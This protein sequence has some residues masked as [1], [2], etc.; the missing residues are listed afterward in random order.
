MA[1][2]PGTPEAPRTVGRKPLS[3]LLDELTGAAQGWLSTC[4]TALAEPPGALDGLLAPDGDVAAALEN[5]ERSSWHPEWS[6][7]RAS[8]EAVLAVARAAAAE[9]GDGS[10]AADL[11]QQAARHWRTS[12]L[13]LPEA[14]DAEA[15][16]GADPADDFAGLM[17]RALRGTLGR[18]ASVSVPVLLDRGRQGGG[19]MADLTVT[20][21]RDGPAGLFPD[22]ERMAFG[23]GDPAFA[24]ALEAGWG[25]APLSL[26]RRCVLWSV[27]ELDG[28]PC[29]RLR[30]GSLGAPLG[31]ALDGLHRRL[32]PVHRSFTM[33]EVLRPRRA[34]TGRLGRD[35]ELLEVG[36][37]DAKLGAAAS[38]GYQVVAP[39]ANRSDEV[40]HK[41]AAVGVELRYA[42]H[43]PE[44][45]RLVR[46]LGRG[47][48]GLL[49]LV[50]LL[51]VLA[52]LVGVQQYRAHEQEQAARQAERESLSRALA[53]LS[54]RTGGEDPLM[55]DL[56]AAAAHDLASTPEA[57]RSVYEALH[58]PARDKLPGAGSWARFT[59]DSERIMT[60]G[61]VEG[62]GLLRE[63]SLTRREPTGPSVRPSRDAFPATGLR[64]HA[65]SPD[66]KLWAVAD[67]R[68][69][70]QLWSVPGGKRVTAPIQ[71]HRSAVGTAVFSP[72][73]GTLATVTNPDGGPSAGRNADA[74]TIRL[75]DTETGALR[76]AIVTDHTGFIHALAFSPDGRLLASGGRADGDGPT[77]RLWDAAN[78][79]RTGK[80]PGEVAEGVSAL[81]FAPDGVT[82]AAGSDDGSVRQW[83][84]VTGRR[85]GQAIVA[86]SERVR[87]LRYT[88]DG[89]V[90]V[91]ASDDT[92]VRLWEARSG[93]SIGEPFAGHTDGIRSLS[94]APDENRLVS[95]DR[96]GTV[97]VWDVNW[98]RYY[99]RP[100][101]E[102]SL[103]RSVAA[104]SPDGDRVA[105]ASW[106]GV[107]LV[108]STDGSGRGWVLGAGAGRVTG[109]AYAPDGLTLATSGAD[110]TVR[111][112]ETA[113]GKTR[114]TLTGHRGAVNALA[115]S[116]DGKT[117][118]SA[119]A[120]GTVRLWETASG[121][122]LRTLTGH[123]GAVNALTYS[124][125]GKTLATS[126]ADGTVRLWETATGKTRHTL[127]G[128]RGA[129]NALAHS[130]DG[131]T[132]AS[133]G[134][135]G[136]VRLWETASG[137]YLRTLTGHV[138][139]V[140]T[141]GFGTDDVLTGGG[142]NGV[143]QW[144]AGSGRV[145]HVFDGVGGVTGLAMAPDGSSF[146]TAGSDRAITRWTTGAPE[147]EAQ[148]LLRTTP[149]VI[150]QSADPG[151]GRVAMLT[152]NTV[153]AS[154]RTPVSA[155][156]D[157]SAE[158]PPGAAD[159]N[160]T[161]LLI[162]EVGPGD[163]GGRVTRASVLEGGTRGQ[164]RFLP[165]DRVDLYTF[166]GDAYASEVA[167]LSYDAGTGEQR[168]AVKLDGRV[169]D[170]PDVPLVTSADGSR[171]AFVSTGKESKGVTVVDAEA[172]RVR[173]TLSVGEEPVT[174]LALTPDGTTLALGRQDGRV[175]LWDARSGRR[176]TSFPAHSEDAV[177]ALAFT[178]DG[179]RLAV[180]TE[181]VQLWTTGPEPRR[182]AEM[183]EAALTEEYDVI[184]A[185]AFSPSGDALAVGRMTDVRV[186]STRTGGR[187]AVFPV[188]ASQ[189]PFLSLGFAPHTP[190]G[191]DG[192]DPGELFL[193]AAL[194]GSTWSGYWDA[195]HVDRPAE[196][197]CERIGRPMTRAEWAGVPRGEKVGYR[198]VCPEGA[199]S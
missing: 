175:D 155:P 47:R 87:A 24:A 12:D 103:L 63:W 167:L 69:S 58:R 129:V 104:Y 84:V 154:P 42:A 110:G 148:H 33:L 168:R 178:P 74:R 180:A 170:T 197:L 32:H 158:L 37:L 153:L 82:L 66:G 192:R 166:R 31:L 119:G 4:R 19:R 86:H 136:T 71:A 62:R 48:T 181:T 113:T 194:K 141:L 54:G 143:W 150:A 16:D 56:Y 128:H 189:S 38:R 29:N 123:R 27:A 90:L 91:T 151:G 117:L 188:W 50:L 145:E 195:A 18:R 15:A 53:A 152:S 109:L 96:A 156:D 165:E 34:L 157:L 59:P 176:T 184:S 79:R 40:V 95:A 26:R 100:L 101:S 75:W 185:L 116:P 196:R 11:R 139:A 51:L 191:K 85:L 118:A 14:A 105:T 43:L 102:R 73:G 132:L 13:L 83:D 88:R 44:A 177:T 1:G 21:L 198:P 121:E 81:E 77:L 140:Q 174:A 112:W 36:G 97:R 68:G 20:C 7:S 49:L 76:R 99:G 126:G 173:H 52:P 115:H 186:L 78:G 169:A 164:V 149:R 131:K 89:A 183:T 142:S 107:V 137:E 171:A 35:G 17:E 134:A 3:V 70:L 190:S 39:S 25:T 2:T 92:T 98:S 187:I 55:A 199:G 67:D 159:L 193:Y 57:E 120:D 144:N 135:D 124:P 106:D 108:W 80:P 160:R 72:D 146:V 45:V 10:T 60:V 46:R 162:A 133:A 182:E 125:D 5:D 130:P 64:T 138:D 172:G 179:R 111:L 23:S 9:P 41:A 8:A 122:Y 161:V 93:E 94:F 127:T 65:V 6:F 163:H 61:Q 147:A 30:E 28:S 22:P 114:H